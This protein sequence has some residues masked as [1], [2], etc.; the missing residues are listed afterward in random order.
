MVTREILAISDQ[1][2]RVIEPQEIYLFGSYASNTNREDS[3]YD[4]YV[5]VEDG[6]NKLQQAQKAYAA[7]R[8]M[9]NRPVDIVVG[10]RSEFNQAVSPN[11]IASVVKREGV[12]LY[13][14]Q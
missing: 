13:A 8:G 11:S 3:D 4:F 9:R 6:T 2:V 1:L 10:H 14:K 5:V 12:R 7:L